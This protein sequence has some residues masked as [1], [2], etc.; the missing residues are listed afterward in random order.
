MRVG[1]PLPGDAVCD[2]MDCSVPSNLDVGE[3]SGVAEAVG[4]R[5]WVGV[6]VTVAVFVTVGVADGLSAA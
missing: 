2:D 6:G 1:V 4:V 3:T 5:V